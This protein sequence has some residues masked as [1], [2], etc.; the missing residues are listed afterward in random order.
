MWSF[1][2]ND[3]DFI[4]EFCQKEKKNSLVLKPHF[5]L[6]PSDLLHTTPTLRIPDETRQTYLFIKLT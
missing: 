1:S 3:L 4:I 6:L 5:R 2:V